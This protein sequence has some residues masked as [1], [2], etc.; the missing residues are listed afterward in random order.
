MIICTKF[1]TT[2][3]FLLEVKYQNYVIKGIISPTHEPQGEDS[4]M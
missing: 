3:K 2:I 4:K 1:R